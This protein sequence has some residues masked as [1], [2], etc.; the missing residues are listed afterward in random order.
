MKRKAIPVVAGALIILILVIFASTRLLTDRPDTSLG[1]QTGEIPSVGQTIA[2]FTVEDVQD[3]PEA[4]GTII[5]FRHEV[6][7]AQLCYIKNDDT[8]RAFAIG[9]RT[10]MADE[11]DINHVFEHSILASSGKYPSHTLFYDMMGKTYN[12]YANALTASAFT[13]YPVASQSEEQLRN[14]ADVVLSCMVSPGVLSDEN[15]FRREALRY[16][17]EDVNDPISMGGTVFTEDLSYMTTIGDNAIN[18]VMDTLYPGEYAANMSGRAWA[19]YRELTFDK[20]QQLYD[21]SYHFDNALLLLYGKLDYDSFLTFLDNEYLSHSPNTHTDLSAY[22]Q[23]SDQS[24]YKE[25]QLYSPAFEGDC[26]QHASVIDYAFDLDGQSYEILH[27]YGVLCGLLNA[28]DSVFQTNLRA[29]GL[30]NASVSLITDTLKPVLRF[31]LSGANPE[32]A[33]TFRSVVEDTLTSIQTDGLDSAPLE[34][35]LKIGRFSQYLSEES[36][37]KAITTYFANILVQWAATGNTDYYGQE[38]KALDEL[39]G[40]EGQELYRRLAGGLLNCSNTALVTTTPQPGL[41]EQIQ[42]EQENYLAEMKASMTGEEL[43]QLIQDTQ[44]YNAWSEE[45]VSNNDFVIPVGDLPDPAPRS[46]FEK[47]SENGI[48]YYTSDVG[49]EGIAYNKLLLDASGIAQ[50]DLFYLDLYIQMV[51]SLGTAQHSDTELEALKQEYLNGFWVENYYPTSNAGDNSRPYLRVTWIN[52]PADQ[53]KSLRLLLDLLQNTQLGDKD[54]FLLWWDTTVAQW[55]PGQ[56]DSFT[57]ADT[58]SNAACGDHREYYSYFFGTEDYEFLSRL[59]QKLESDPNAMGEL[60]AKIKQISDTVCQ[61]DHMVSM[62]VTEEE[63]LETAAT[64]TRKVLEQLPSRPSEAP[65]YDLPSFP[66]K[67]GVILEDSLCTSVGKVYLNNMDDISGVVFPFLVA[68]QDQ[69]LLPE[70]R[71]TGQAYSTEFSFFD[72]LEQVYVYSYADQKAAAT[73]DVFLGMADA[74]E[75]LDLT[76]E[77]LDGYIINAYSVVTMPETET[78]NAID[79]MI[80]DLCGFDAERMYQWIQQIK[81][82]TVDDQQE[83]VNM[84]RSLLGQMKIV[85]AGNRSILSADSDYYDA[86]YDYRCS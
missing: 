73:V 16:T 54:S 18:N 67:T 20:V 69:Y 48:T 29:A 53:E 39:A 60:Q 61:R 43:N 40:P 30:G 45:D 49:T 65:R 26:V 47:E 51:G 71:Y 42:A 57:M 62:L 23:P 17:L 2:G 22:D 5:T 80:D 75:Q 38:Q 44:G 84:L 72:S 10:P 3:F 15:F 68:L 59:R 27:Q 83:A 13:M 70:L 41:A 9:Y 74:L 64:A 8:N 85:T 31:E 4:K 14:M 19:N 50:E 36:S 35:A 25:A 86:V 34:R 66:E 58:I 78:Q 32:E 7:G 52:D 21:L 77:E 79:A 55:N 63:K 6:S 24:G 37:D 1:A 81:T 33:Q 28:N 82:T 46:G 12:T 76:Q 56:T 11:S